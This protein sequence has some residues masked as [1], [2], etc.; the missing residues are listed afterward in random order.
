V[1]CK[2]CSLPVC[3]KA[4]SWSLLL[5]LFKFKRCRS[6]ERPVSHC[7]DTA[8]S[9]AY[10]CVLISAVVQEYCNHDARLFKVC[11]VGDAVHMHERA[12]LPNLCS[13]LYGSLAFDSQKPYPTAEDFGMQPSTAT[14]AA[15]AV[16]NGATDGISDDGTTANA[17][18]QQQHLQQQQP[19]LSLETA[20][21]A[22]QWLR[23]AFGLT[24]FG[25][26][27]I[28]ACETGEVTV[29]DVNYFPS[30]RDLSDFPAALR[31]HLHTVAVAARSAE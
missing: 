2:S 11:V 15:T 24:L 10:G 27:L 29:I 7:F 13:G 5:A 20:H 8:V 9:D 21:R 1:K 22:A 23:E 31:S 26:D 16:S 6:S 28:V 18:Q 12:S 4:A 17:S 19:H 3:L 25:F 30:F 14:T